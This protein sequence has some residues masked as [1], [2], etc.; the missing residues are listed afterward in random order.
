MVLGRGGVVG[1]GGWGGGWQAGSGGR[2]SCAGG[3]TAGISKRPS[4]PHTKQSR[5]KYANGII[6]VIC[7]ADISV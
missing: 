3:R 2:H 7:F 1:L 6:T 4:S 5:H